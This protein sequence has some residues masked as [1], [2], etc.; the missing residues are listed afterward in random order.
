M[1]RMSIDWMSM[2]VLATNQ[3]CEIRSDFKTDNNQT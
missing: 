2:R 1:E 3:D